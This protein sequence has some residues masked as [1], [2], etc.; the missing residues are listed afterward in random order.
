MGIGKLGNPNLILKRKFRYTFEINW[1]CGPPVPQWYVKIAARPQ[2]DIDEVELNFLNG[3]DW[4]PGKGRWQPLTVTYVDAATYELSPLYS[5]VATV[6]DFTQ[7]NPQ[8]HL[9]QSERP[10]YR[11]TATLRMYDGCGTEVENW[12]L[13]NCWPQSINFGDLDYSNSEEATIELT[14]RYSQVRYESNP[15]CGPT[16]QPCCRGC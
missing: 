10:G 8:D 4:V 5:W 3:V 2:L 9:P 1:P 12:T 15:F 16:P 14:I 13:Q 6:Y 7:Q 11:G